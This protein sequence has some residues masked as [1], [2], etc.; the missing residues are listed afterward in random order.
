M[1]WKWHTGL[2]GQVLNSYFVVKMYTRLYRLKKTTTIK[3]IYQ[4][5][6]LVLFAQNEIILSLI[7]SFFARMFS[8]PSIS[9]L[10]KF[11]ILS[12]F[13]YIIMH[14]SFKYL[15]FDN[16]YFAFITEYHSIP[17]IINSFQYVS[18][19]PQKPGFSS[20][21]INQKF[22]LQMKTVIINPLNLALVFVYTGHTHMSLLIWDTCPTM[23]QIKQIN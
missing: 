13:L 23:L 1:W 21:D 2:M 6:K 9:F 10:Q 3:A 18:S 22:I 17:V 12:I 16:I 11:N 20:Y 19:T 5:W 15:T 4:L 8:F 14:V 7:K